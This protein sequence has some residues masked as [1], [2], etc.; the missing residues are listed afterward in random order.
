VLV[1]AHDEEKVIGDTLESL[2]S[3]DYPADRFRVF[4]VADHCTDRTVE[5][6]TAAG[7]DVRQNGSGSRGKGPALQWLLSGVLAD[8]RRDG[9][10]FDAVVIIDADT[11]VDPGFLGAMAARFERGAVVVQ[12]Q[13]RVRDP[14]ATTAAA[15]RSAAL[16][17]RHH[18]RPLGRTALG[19]SCGLFGNGM[20]FSTDVLASRSWSDHLTED[21]ELQNELLLEG[22]V[23]DYAPDAVVEAAMPAT[24]EASRTQHERWERGRIEL[25]RRFVP[26]LVRLAARDRGRRVA[27]VDGVLDHLVPPMSVLVAATGVVVSAS[28]VVAVVRRT[29]CSRGWW[30][31]VALVGHVTSGLVL[32]KVPPAV[33]R[34]LLHAPALVVW[35]VRLWARMVLRP[36]A[37]GWARTARDE[38]P[39][40]DDQ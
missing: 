29:R 12:G 6:A 20:A 40:G 16:A 33:Y 31:V 11:V 9:T 3:A 25:A 1:P 36:G 22:V 10:V 2:A 21:I 32:A 19:G 35:K 34:S 13:Y 30:M 37:E 28:S 7:V 8:A 27:A 4:V 17:L 24:L 14:G 38:R 26:Q 23:V 15:L 39:A 18:L 5:I